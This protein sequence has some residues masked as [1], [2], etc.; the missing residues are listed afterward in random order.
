MEAL[1]THTTP[2][3]RRILDRMAVLETC[4]DGNSAMQRYRELHRKDLLREFYFVHTDREEPEI[5]KRHW[6]GVR[7]WRGGSGIHADCGL[8]SGRDILYHE[9]SGRYWRNGLWF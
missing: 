1:E 3:N 5:Y 7:G 6:L 4:T 9:F 2:E 8:L